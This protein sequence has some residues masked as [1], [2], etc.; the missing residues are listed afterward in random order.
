MD[1]VRFHSW[2]GRY[3]GA[4]SRVHSRGSS[5]RAAGVYVIS[6]L[7]SGKIYIGSAVNVHDRLRHH[8]HRLLAN[9]HRNCHLQAAWN[10]YGSAS[11]SMRPLL[12]CSVDDR[13]FYEQACID[14]FVKMYGRARLYNID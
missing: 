9:A 2:M 14:G 11:F 1:R 5:M 3:K 13:V 7:V 4:I 8:R 10:M 12:V 6:S